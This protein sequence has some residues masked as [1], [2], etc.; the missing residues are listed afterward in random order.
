MGRLPPGHVTVLLR[1]AFEHWGLFSFEPQRWV[2]CCVRVGACCK[3]EE[4]PA[5]CSFCEC[6]FCGLLCLIYKDKQASG[7]ERVDLPRPSLRFQGAAQQLLGK[8]LWTPFRVKVAA[9]AQVFE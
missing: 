8:Q 5:Q 3:F 4:V 7:S 9:G 1:T 6:S 2:P